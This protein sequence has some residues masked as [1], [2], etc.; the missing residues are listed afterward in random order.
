MEPLS[1]CLGGGSHAEAL[2]DAQQGHPCSDLGVADGSM[3][4][5]FS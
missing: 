5:S 4:A 1:R 3:G 2:S